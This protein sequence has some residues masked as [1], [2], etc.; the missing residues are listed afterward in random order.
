MK[1][2]LVGLVA[3]TLAATACG[4]TADKKDTV[5]PANA[6]VANNDANSEPNSAPTNIVD[7]NANA[8]ADANAD[9]NAETNA[10]PNADANA[11]TNA[12]VNNTNDPVAVDCVS[13]LVSSGG[14]YYALSALVTD[15]GAFVEMVHHLAATPTSDPEETTVLASDVLVEFTPR[16]FAF[17]AQEQYL[18]VQKDETEALYRGT[19]SGR[20]EFAEQVPV[21]CWPTALEHA[22]QYDPATGTCVDEAGNLAR[23]EIP[24]M[25]ALRTGFGQCTDFV[26][27]LNGDALG[28]PTFDFIDLRGSDFNQASLHFADLR[29]VQ[30]EGA[31]LT[32]FDFGYARLTGTIDEFTSVPTDCPV[33]EDG[34]MLD[35][36]R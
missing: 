16:V 20:S 31:D 36:T 35:C 18:D 30:L 17:E 22:A 26:G 6:E 9:V 3:V 19:M 8:N 10:E 21:T 33:S 24:F 25:V 34:S 11:D 5:G 2:I 28:Y 32:D 12:A 15:D 4:E 13:E 7:A 23:N 29:D 1:R 14:N 27:G